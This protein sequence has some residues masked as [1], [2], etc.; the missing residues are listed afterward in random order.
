VAKV[1]NSPATEPEE[2]ESADSPASDRLRQDGILTAPHGSD[3]LPELEMVSRSMG[4][5]LRP[6][7]VQGYD[8]L[9]QL[10]TGERPF[11]S[12]E[13]NPLLASSPVPLA[14]DK[15]SYA[16]ARHAVAAGHLPAADE[17]RIEDFLAAVEG[18]YPA[19]RDPIAL[20]LAAGR[21]PFGERE[22][23]LLGVGLRAGG[24]AG[25]D[26]ATGAPLPV[27]RGVKVQVA[28]NPQ[29]VGAYR[30][31]GHATATLTGPVASATEVDLTSGNEA[32][33][34]FELWLKPAG[35][36]PVATV[37]LSWKDPK[38]G[39]Q[40]RVVSKVGRGQ[41]A[42]SFAESAAPLQAMALEAEAARAL[43]LHATPGRGLARVVDLANQVQPQLRELPSFGQ[44]VQFVTQAEKVRAN[45]G[46]GARR[47]TAE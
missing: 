46:V 2:K 9:Y 18:L 40:R 30:L 26:P 3:R 25:A 27:A 1:E 42:A 4:R 22:L 39:A 37:T 5:G 29:V 8:Y 7:I 10:K 6:P 32:G 11:V 38:N 16:L 33:G 23:Q 14:C 17:V 15:E 13:V 43:R 45:P 21:A 36:D 20:H 19:T 24:T 28:F 41:F 34:L 47:A 12:P 44:F 35:A 31:V